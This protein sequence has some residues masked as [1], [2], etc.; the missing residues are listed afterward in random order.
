MQSYPA[1]QSSIAG[2]LGFVV[3]VNPA[4]QVTVA[5]EGVVGVHVYPLGQTVA[6]VVMSVLICVVA[7]D[8]GALAI[9]LFKVV[10]VGASTEPV[11]AILF[12]FCQ[13]FN[14]FIVNEPKYPVAT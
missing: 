7:D 8:A 4:G 5:D 10:I 3:Q 14:A 13:H 9:T 12:C 11:L 1:G 6:E 2:A